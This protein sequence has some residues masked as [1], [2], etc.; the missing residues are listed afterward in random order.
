MLPV[1]IRRRVDDV[2][3]A[4]SSGVNFLASYLAA[5]Y[6]PA[7]VGSSVSFSIY[8]AQLWSGIA[9]IIFY[10]IVRL[11]DA[12][13]GKEF[14][15]RWSWLLSAILLAIIWLNAGLFLILAIRFG[16]I[17]GSKPTELYSR[18]LAFAA[19]LVLVII[20]CAVLALNLDVRHFYPLGACLFSLLLALATGRHRIWVPLPKK[21]FSIAFHRPEYITRTLR[22]ATLDIYIFLVSLIL[23]FVIRYSSSANVSAEFLKIY[24]AMAIA[25][26]FVTVIESRVLNPAQNISS[27]FGW[28]ICTVMSVFS[29]ISVLLW[30]LLAIKVSYPGSFFASA[31]AACAIFSGNFLA[32]IR[33][34]GSINAILFCSVTGTILM[35]IIFLP[36]LFIKSGIE[37]CLLAMFTN[38][39]FQLVMLCMAYFKM[40][41]HRAETES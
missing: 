24:S 18:S 27:Q 9:C 35:A 31:G 40:G 14:L 20:I 12:Q 32:K 15:L 34:F 38:L 39:V 8:F 6:L 30:C 37:D 33:R 1:N 23:L 26:L 36:L 17:R 13:S 22:R 7:A 5:T 3:V 2:L 11:E 28:K 41:I 4:G 10:N 16:I 25:G 19:F 29:F 21:I